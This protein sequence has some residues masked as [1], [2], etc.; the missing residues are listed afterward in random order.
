MTILVVGNGYSGRDIMIDLADHAKTVYFCNRGE[1]LTCPLPSNVEQLPALLELTSKGTA[2]FVNG[3]ENHVDAV[4]L[5]TGYKYSFPYLRNDSGILIDSD[6]RIRPLYKH[7]FNIAHPSMAIIGMNTGVVPFLYFDLQVR[8]V[9]S[10]WSG[11][12][13]LP[14]KEEMIVSDEETYQQRLREGLPPH[15][16]GHFLGAGDTHWDFYREMADLGGSELVSPESKVIYGEW[17]K[18]RTNDVMNY[19]HTNV[20]FDGNK[21]TFLRT[22]TRSENR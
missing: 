15:L 9:M 22:R 5:A 12:K 8:W 2:C 11:E 18:L 20:F 16:A 19:K 10:V 7:T 3:E 4:I 14:T 1:F 6:K 13:L 17:M 21:C